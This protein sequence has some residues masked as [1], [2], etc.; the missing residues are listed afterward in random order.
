MRVWI[1]GFEVWGAGFWVWGLGIRGYC[2]DSPVCA[3][4]VP[5]RG[6]GVRDQRDPVVITT[7]HPEAVR[8]LS[9]CSHVTA[10]EPVDCL[11]ENTRTQLTALIFRAHKQDVDG[12][13]ALM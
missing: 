1:V 2:L 13:M 12:L 4:Q 7:I 10:L 6:R 8:C 5:D 3:A 9:D 11:G